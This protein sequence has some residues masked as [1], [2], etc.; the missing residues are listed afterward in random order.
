MQTQAFRDAA[1]D[2]CCV[3]VDKAQNGEYRGRLFHYYAAEAQPF[4]SV[5]ELIVMMD[6]LCDQL[7]YP[8]ASKRLRSFGGML[9]A[10]EKKEVT[11]LMSRE[12][13][14]GNKGHMATFVVHVTH[15]QNATWQGTVVWAEKDQKA[16]FRSAMELLRLMDSAVETSLPESGSSKDNR[17]SF[18]EEQTGL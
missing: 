12:E 16:N 15:R 13:L 9:P 18:T 3:C 8:Q 10:A 17:P 2:L 5:L 11:R 6:R 14:V 1:P 4:R 7:G